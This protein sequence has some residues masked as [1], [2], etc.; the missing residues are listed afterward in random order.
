MLSGQ[1]CG[2]FSASLEKS[3]MLEGSLMVSERQL[4]FNVN[5]LTSWTDKSLLFCGVSANAKEFRSRNYTYILLKITKSLIL[6][7]KANFLGIV[8]VCVV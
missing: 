1:E 2:R 3:K 5:F 7:I 6:I 8:C 4:R